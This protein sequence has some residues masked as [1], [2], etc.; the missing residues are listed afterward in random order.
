M[1]QHVEGMADG[2]MAMVCESKGFEHMKD[3]V[4][5]H[6]AFERR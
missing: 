3:A 4:V 6:M 2:D 5:E 1:E